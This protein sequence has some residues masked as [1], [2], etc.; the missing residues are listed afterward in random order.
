MPDLT[1]A[2][3]VWTIPL[4]ADVA[5]EDREKLLQFALVDE[6][7]EEHVLFHESAIVGQHMYV[8]LSG[9]VEI[10]KKDKS[11]K[12]TVLAL[13]R[14]GHF[15]GEMSLIEQEKRSATA[16]VKTKASILVITRTNFDLMMKAAPAIANKMLLVFVKTLSQ[17]LRNTSDLY[18]AEHQGKHL[19]I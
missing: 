9:E 15:F 3:Q 2:Q 4:F 5:E 13:L 12:D 17:R 19:H 8:I 6:F 11:G 1:L 7:A 14:R 10:L 18:A 16:R